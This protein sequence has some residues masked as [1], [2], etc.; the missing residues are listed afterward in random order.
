MKDFTAGVRRAAG[1]RGVLAALER[2]TG[3]EPKQSGDGWSARCPAHD[4]R[5]PSLSVS[6]GADGRVLLHCHA[7]C[8]TED[9]A[10]KLGLTTADLMPERT[11]GDG[12]RVEA[13]YVYTDE[14]GTPVLRVVRTVPKGFYQQ[15]PDGRDGWINGTKGTPK[16]LYRLPDVNAAT[17]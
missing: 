13:T 17:D 8:P 1:L 7:G 11:N 6:V 12:R 2:V 3:F 16:P 5:N 14:H 10:A 15:R 4:D 9:V